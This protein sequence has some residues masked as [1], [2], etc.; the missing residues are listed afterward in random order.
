[1]SGRP[2]LV[3]GLTGGIGMGKSTVAAMFRDLAVPVHDA[4]GA[5]HRLYA[6]GGAAVGP[7]GAAFPGAVRSGAID[8]AALS[9]IVVGDADAMGR[10]EGIVHPLVR[11]EETA[12]L[13]AHARE[14]VAVLDIPLLFETGGDARVDET[15]VVSAPE[16]MRRARVLSRPGM[17]KNKLDAIVARQVP[18][19]E[20]RARA[21]HVIDTGVGLDETRAAVAVL[22][23]RWR[24]S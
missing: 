11:A 15:V 17:T 19:A 5:V 7:V 9:A 13:A 2:A 3:V 16:P 24:G 18:D 6:A 10:L 23:A 22:V 14:P 20:K 21:T 12:F 8:R 1:M 4:D